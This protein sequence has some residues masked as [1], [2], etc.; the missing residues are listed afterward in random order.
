MDFL[1][2][3][4]RSLHLFAVVVWFGGLI[5]QAVVFMPVAG[6]E[7]KQSDP[8][9]RHTIRRFQ[10]FVWMCVWTLLVTG[11]ALML[12]NPR[13]IFFRYDDAWS[14][15][16][17]VKQMVF[18]VMIFFSFG[19]ARMFSRV[20]A[21]LNGGGTDAQITP[22]VKQLTGFGKMN[23]TLAIIALLAAAGMRE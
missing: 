6:V 9:T 21:L 15:L 20:D 7:G 18:V 22:Y 19:Y 23:I 13:F 8:V 2:W 5:Y 14:V 10:P 1:L 16:L 4:A 17:G 12:F 3:T 11:I